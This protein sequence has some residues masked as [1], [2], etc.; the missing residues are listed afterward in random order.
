MYNARII[1][2]ALLLGS[3]PAWALWTP[4]TDE[5]VATAVSTF[6]EKTKDLARTD[7]EGRQAA[8][9]EVAGEFSIAEMSA[10][11]IQKL[12]TAGILG[13]LD[14][15]DEVRARLE[16]LSKT[17]D[18]S[19]ARATLLAINYLPTS[20]SGLQ[21]EELAEARKR[22]ARARAQAAVASLSHPG[23][24]EAFNAGQVNELLGQLTPYNTEALAGL[25]SKILAF[26]HL[27]NDQLPTAML[28]RSAGLFDLVASDKMNFDPAAKERV[29]TR[30]VG[31]LSEKAESLPDEDRARTGLERTVRYLQ[32]AFARGQLV[33]H[34]APELNITWTN[35][36]EPITSLADLRGKVVVIDFWA[37]WCG[38]CIASFPEV[39]DL[40]AHYEGYPVTVLGVTSIQGFHINHKAED[41]KERRIDTKDD[42]E[43]EMALMTEFIQQMDVTWPVA[44]ATQDV[45]NPEFG[46]R[47]I[48]HVAII[49]PK[50]VVRYRGL[51]PK[52][53][54]TDK[55]NKIDPLLREAGLPVPA[56][57]PAPVAGDDGAK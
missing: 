17:P 20:T 55:T 31:L 26:E 49:D 38:P 13:L 7:R 54:L 36:K 22:D 9:V 24:Q 6:T 34:T 1:I 40:V 19:G 43:R 28:S 39:R 41:P 30:L 2:A 10:D 52:S 42:P 8:A 14:K 15:R 53:P 32:G 35:A 3:A 56:A 44:F 11:Q 12:E 4:P 27:L 23:M 21:G 33:G 5:E 29:R 48:P 45:F 47:G 51:H 16:Q 25:E 57:P 37:T 18:L 50:G 46:V